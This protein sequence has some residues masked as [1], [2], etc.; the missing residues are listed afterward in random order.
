ML[1]NSKKKKKKINKKCG[2]K[3]YFS[4]NNNNI[5]LSPFTLF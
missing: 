1:K 5:F 4:L 2:F 3:N